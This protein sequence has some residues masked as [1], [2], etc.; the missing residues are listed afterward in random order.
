VVG[1]AAPA[2]ANPGIEA[3]AGEICEHSLN[4][5]AKSAD[6]TL[7]KCVKKAGDKLPHWV[8]V[9]KDE[10]GDGKPGDG[11][12]GDG[13]P[14]PTFEFGYDDVQLSSRK[15]APGYKTKFTVTCPTAVTITGNG[16]TKTPL[17]VK[18]TGD[19]T[20]AAT[21][22]FRKNLPDPVIATVVCKDYGSVKYST[23]P[24]KS[25]N[26]NGGGNKMEP[27]TPKIPNGRIDTGDGSMYMQGHNSAAPMLAAG[28]GA[29]M[30]AGLGALALR[31]RTV[32]ERS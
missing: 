10:P 7:L 4:Q 20:W 24:A 17:T 12:P 23:S 19:D 30:A 2:L 1:L 26:D 15:V 25:E 21:G 6:G 27:K 22:T 5:T 16:Y 11:E 32:R 29:L 14:T 8:V 18:K 9:D 13:T 3:K 31:R 28:W